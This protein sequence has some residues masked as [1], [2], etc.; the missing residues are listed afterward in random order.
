MK[1]LSYARLAR[2]L[3]ALACQSDHCTT[4]GG[5]WR[6]QLATAKTILDSDARGRPVL[7]HAAMCNHQWRGRPCP[8]PVD[9]AARWGRWLD[10]LTDP[11]EAA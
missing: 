11:K 6:T 2:A 4:E 9:H 10:S 3:H 1:P 8:D 5:H 7:L